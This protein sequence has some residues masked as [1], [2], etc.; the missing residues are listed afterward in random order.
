MEDRSKIRLVYL[1]T[2]FGISLWLIVI[3]LAPY[4]ETR[5]SLWAGFIYSLFSPVC[6]QQPSRCFFLFGSPLAVCARCLG[7]YAGFF[8]GTLAFPVLRG[9]S[10]VPIPPMRTFLFFSF[11]IVLDTLG[12]MIS[13]W[14]TP[15]WARFALGVLWGVL[16]PFYFIPGVAD[17]VMK[18]E[19]LK[20]ERSGFINA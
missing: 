3:F 8:C 9:L 14:M 5:S 2:L 4:L 16:L 11:P 20:G 19:R 15:G 10:T 17:A 12:N 13:L 18:K 1:L 7:I 6:H